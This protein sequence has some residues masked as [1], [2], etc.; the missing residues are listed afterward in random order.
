MKIFLIRHGDKQKVESTDSATKRSVALNQLGIKHIEIL[1]DYLVKNYPELQGLECIFSSPFPR[2][3]QTAEILR[4]R[5]GMKEIKL[6]PLLEELYPTNDYSLSKEARNEMFRQAM[7]NID[8][9][10][11]DKTTFR[12][13]IQAFLSFLSDNY[14][15]NSMMLIST[16]G[17]LIRNTVYLLFPE[18]KPPL[19]KILES[20]IHNGGITILDYD[21]KKFSLEKFDFVDHL[22]DLSV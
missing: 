1:S 6:F 12:Q 22:V 21:G 16:H 10:S 7:N 20:G 4:N 9:V 18:L 14:Q 15:E 3:V 13:R 19:E 8:L 11:E 17:A 5:L 2:T